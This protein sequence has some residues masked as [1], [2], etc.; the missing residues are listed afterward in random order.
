LGQHVACSLLVLIV[1]VIV[2]SIVIDP[3]SPGQ[4]RRGKPITITIKITITNRRVKPT[5]R[6]SRACALRL[7]SPGE[8]HMMAA[9]VE[10]PNL[11]QEKRK[12]WR[13]AT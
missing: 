2:I 1:I 6:P 7:K 3:G 11:S 9:F 5:R 12:P 4:K 13:Q 10:P 8:S